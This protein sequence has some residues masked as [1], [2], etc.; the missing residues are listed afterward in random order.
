M[1]EAAGAGEQQAAMFRTLLEQALDQLQA[2]RGGG[3]HQL[4]VVVRSERGA[5][6]RERVADVAH[7]VLPGRASAHPDGEREPED[8]AAAHDGTHP[9]LPLKWRVSSLQVR[10][11][12]SV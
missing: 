6:V 3:A 10:P 4:R 12:D 9:D 8:G 5:V 2:E 11:P 1:R 7:R